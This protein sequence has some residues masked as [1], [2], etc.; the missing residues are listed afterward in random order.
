MCENSSKN[1]HDSV[2]LEEEET[3]F[4]SAYDYTCEKCEFKTMNKDNVKL[5]VES[6]HQDNEQMKTCLLYTSPSPRDS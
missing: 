1:D 2:A 3:I 5:H 4:L 6:C